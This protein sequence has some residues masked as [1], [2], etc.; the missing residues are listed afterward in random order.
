MYTKTVIAKMDNLCAPVREQ[1]ERNKISHLAVLN[2]CNSHLGKLKAEQ[3]TEDKRGDMKVSQKKD[4]A[5]VTVK[6]G[7]VQFTGT[8]NTV[9]CF[10]AWH[11]AVQ[12]CNDIALMEYVAIPAQF[13]E[14]LKFAAVKD[15]ETVN[16]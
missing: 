11:D 5:K 4:T 8:Y 13:N 6:P 16:S 7:S 10:I 3:T 9:S 15:G 2:A 1:M 12:K 14:W